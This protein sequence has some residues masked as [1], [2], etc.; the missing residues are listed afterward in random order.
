MA[1]APVLFIAPTRIG[2]AV[3]SS[4]VLRHILSSMP[5]ARL[6][7]ATSPLAAPL[8]EACPQLARIIPLQKQPYNGHWLKLWREVS[9]QRWAAVWDMRGSLLSLLLRAGSRH[10][11]SGSDA[12]EPKLQHYARQLRTGPLPYPTLWTHAAHHAQAK[13]MLPDGARYII[14][15]PCANWPPKEW[16]LD[17]YR[18]LGRAMLREGGLC[19]DYRPVIICAAHERDRALPLVEALAAYRP[20][21]LTRGALPLLSIYACM[22]RAQG[23]IGNDSGLM[24]MAAA[25]GIPTLGLFGPTPAIIYQPCGARSAFLRAPGDALDALEVTAVIEAFARLLAAPEGIE[26]PVE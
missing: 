3:L 21:D 10:R 17:A 26:A 14:F 5:Q 22:A 1:S 6:T 25:A 9:R 4:A 16:P 19:T 20:V 8:F 18:A 24:H 2:D 15:A 11:F 12:P 7:I 23:F 13:A